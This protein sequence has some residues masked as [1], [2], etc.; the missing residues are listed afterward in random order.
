MAPEMTREPVSPARS[1]L[2]RLAVPLRVVVAL[3]ALWLWLKSVEAAARLLF[4][5]GLRLYLGF[6]KIPFSFALRCLATDPKTWFGLALLLALAVVYGPL[7][8]ALR[9]GATGLRWLLPVLTLL[10]AGRVVAGAA[11]Q[12]PYANPFGF[13]SSFGP[14]QTH[15]L[16]GPPGTSMPDYAVRTN[17]WGYRG[18]EWSL[19]APPGVRRALLVGDSFV[20]GAGIQR[21]Q[22]MLDQ[23]LERELSA[24]SGRRWEV[25]N[26]AVSPAA[27]WYYVHAL[28]AVGRRMHPDLY[29]MSF[30]SYYDLEPWEVQRVKTGLSPRVVAMMDRFGVSQQLHHLGAAIG[31][32]YAQRGAADAKTRADLRREFEALVAFLDETGGRLVIWEPMGPNAFFDDFRRHPRITFARW[33]D[34]PGLPPGLEIGREPLAFRGDSHPTA[35]GNFYFARAIAVKALAARFGTM[36]Q[37]HR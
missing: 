14:H 30:G 16:R 28:M 4:G 29:V 33:E 8:R 21:E 3:A 9:A 12:P 5:M 24:R 1:G 17:A 11:D 27:L 32:Q 18:R 15:V 6:V 26:I 22:D 37:V 25:I 36:S 7:W 13:Y 19:Q 35:Q 23:Q 10:G 2:G 34:V 20:W 31:Q